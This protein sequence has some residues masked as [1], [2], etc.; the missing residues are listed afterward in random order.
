MPDGK[1]DIQN[2]DLRFVPVRNKL[3][4][5]CINVTHVSMSSTQ[6]LEDVRI[7]IFSGMWF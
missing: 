1:T 2:N 4:L 5:Y 6:K 7:K 3:K